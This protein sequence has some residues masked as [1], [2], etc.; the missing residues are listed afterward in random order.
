MIRTLVGPPRLRL[1]ECFSAAIRDHAPRDRHRTSR[2]GSRPETNAVRIRLRNAI[3]AKNSRVSR[4][5]VHK[6]SKPA[7][8]QCRCRRDVAGFRARGSPGREIAASGS[9]SAG[10]TSMTALCPTATQV[11]LPRA[12]AGWMMPI[13]SSPNSRSLDCGTL[14]CQMTTTKR[15]RPKLPSAESIAAAGSHRTSWTGAADFLSWTL[16]SEK[17]CGSRCCTGST[18]DRRDIPSAGAAIAHLRESK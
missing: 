4:R 12:R 13:R 6:Y 8:A 1:L 9:S 15:S 14:K 5:D 2:H 7:I 18:I 16:P 3:G 10:R 17:R 11:Q